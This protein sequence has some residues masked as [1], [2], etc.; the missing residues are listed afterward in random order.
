MRGVKFDNKHSYFQWGLMLKS[1][2]K[3]SAPEPKTNYVDIPGVHGQLDLS[4][5][6]TGGVRYKNR[7]IEME[8]IAM[9][10]RLI[11]SDI[12]SEILD[13]VH[14][15]TLKITLDDDPLNYYTGMVTVDTPEWD[16][17]A[18]M[19]KMTAEVSPFKKNNEGVEIL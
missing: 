15:K 2:P 8:F 16:K 12:Y 6:L 18:V 3:V 19:L 17:K 1:A 14:G 7:K 13:A 9:S 11:W 10:D 5:L 4:T